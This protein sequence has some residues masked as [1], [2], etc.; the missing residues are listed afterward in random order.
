M[1][2]IIYTCTYLKELLATGFILFEVYLY[3][4]IATNAF[5]QYV[6]RKWEKGHNFRMCIATNPRGLRGIRLSKNSNRFYPVA[7]G[8]IINTI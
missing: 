3:V 1:Y 6:I 5:K 4:F 2:V 7:R 8:W